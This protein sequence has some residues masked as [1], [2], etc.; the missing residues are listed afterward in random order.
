MASRCASKPLTIATMKPKTFFYLLTLAA[1]LCAGGCYAIKKPWP[2]GCCII[3]A[4]ASLILYL[5]VEDGE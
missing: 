4:V 5:A 3:A 2:T 1:I